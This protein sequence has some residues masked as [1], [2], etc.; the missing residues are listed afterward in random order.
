MSDLLAKLKMMKTQQ[1]AFAS[2]NTRNRNQ[3]LKNL[4]RQ[5]FASQ[6]KILVANKKDL[7]RLRF[8]NMYDRLLLTGERIADMAITLNKVAAMPDPLGRVFEKQTLAN[9]LY[10]ERV[11]VPLGLVGVIYESGRMSPWTL[12]LYA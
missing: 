7:K 8:K 5:L 4:A 12:R 1:T 10:I 2:I 11:A 9:G 3:L 6:K